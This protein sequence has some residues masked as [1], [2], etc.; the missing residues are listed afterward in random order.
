MPPFR[1]RTRVNG[2]EEGPPGN[3][4]LREQLQ[5]ELVEASGASTIPLPAPSSPPSRTATAPLAAQ[6]FEAFD[7]AD[8]P[9]SFPSSSFWSPSSSSWETVPSHTPTTP[10]PIRLPTQPSRTTTFIS[11]FPPAFLLDR[12]TRRCSSSSSRSPSFIRDACTVFC[13]IH[14]I[15][16]LLPLL[17][18]FYLPARLLNHAIALS[19]IGRVGAW[20]RLW[21]A[22]VVWGEK[23]GLGVGRRKWRLF[24]DH[25]VEDSRKIKDHGGVPC[26]NHLILVI[27]ASAKSSIPKVGQLTSNS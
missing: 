20:R 3:V 27:R 24:G 14:F 16:I 17:L 1:R 7:Y 18:F 9:S 4:S 19:A 11:L 5:S 15:P 6:S 8:S 25:S 2:T 12:Y 26:F 23:E 10:Y 13:A 21:R 22:V